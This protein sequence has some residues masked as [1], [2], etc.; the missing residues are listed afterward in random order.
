MNILGRDAVVVFGDN[1]FISRHPAV[2]RQERALIF[3]QEYIE[4]GLRERDDKPAEYDVF[5]VS[6]TKI[7]QNWQ[8]IVGSTLPNG[9]YYEVTYDGDKKKIYLDVYIKHANIEFSD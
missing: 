9:E 1:Q 6:F 3:V 7:L 5:I 4:A 8:A 2:S